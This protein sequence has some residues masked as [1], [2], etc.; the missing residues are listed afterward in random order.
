M[1]FLRRISALV[2]F[3]IVGG[4]VALLVW[5]ASG[6]DA[7][8]EAQSSLSDGSDILVNTEPWLTFVPVEGSDVGL[9]LYPG[10]RVPPEAYA[11]VARRIARRGYTVII[12]EMALGM[13][14]FSSS[15]A[16]D[17]MDARQ[18]IDR[19]VIGGH[20]LGGAMAT[21]F[22]ENNP[23]AVEGLLMWAAYPAASVDISGEG[24]FVT[25]IAGTADGLVSFREVSE[26]RDRMPLS[27]EIVPIEGGNHAQ[28]G[29]YGDQKGDGEATI[30]PEEQ[31]SLIV[32]ASVRLLD[33]VRYG[34][35]A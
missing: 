34:G 8:L 6:P 20:S 22:I 14:I 33:R 15:I 17:I 18:E 23:G 31:W 21:S 30:E 4:F 26:A 5:S 35:S 32:E 25:A 13:A 1:H 12:P 29:A 7:G 3:L 11:P 10:A 9:I 24:I 19:W 27:Y 16:D 28:F 2:A